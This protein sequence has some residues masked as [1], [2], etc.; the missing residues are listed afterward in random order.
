[1]TYHDLSFCLSKVYGGMTD[2]LIHCNKSKT[3]TFLLHKIKNQG[4]CAKQFSHFLYVHTSHIVGPKI[5][6][7]VE[8]T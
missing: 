3:Y 8:L 2:T 7:V 4:I 6:T 5:Q 1:M